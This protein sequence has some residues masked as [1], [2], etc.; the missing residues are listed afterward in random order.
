MEKALCKGLSPV[1]MFGLDEVMTHCE[2]LKAK[3]IC[4]WC[5]ATARCLK[6]ALKTEDQWGV[7]GGQS[8]AERRKLLRMASGNRAVAF[9]LWESITHSQEG[10]AHAS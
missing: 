6:L 9:A 7:W 1:V 5:H 2:I 3:A 4:G 10:V 8:A